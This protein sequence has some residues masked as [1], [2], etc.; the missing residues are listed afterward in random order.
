MRGLFFD[1]RINI[2]AAESLHDISQNALKTIVFLIAEKRGR[3]FLFNQLP[4]QFADGGN[5]FR[6]F[7][8]ISDVGVEIVGRQILTV[9]TVEQNKAVGVTGDD[10]QQ[11]F[12]F[13]QSQFVGAPGGLNRF[14]GGF[15]FGEI[16][17]QT[18][19]VERVTFDQI[20]F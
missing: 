5:G 8:F 2:F 7:D 3:L 18:T 15:E 6:V 16:V 4:F 14:D 11:A 19:F 17:F 10:F 9:E 12:G 20:I 13:G 1:T